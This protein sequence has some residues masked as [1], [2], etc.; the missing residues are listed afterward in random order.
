ML[1][2][3]LFAELSVPAFSLSGFLSHRCSLKC[4]S[5]GSTRQSLRS[6]GQAAA[7]SRSGGHTAPQCPGTWESVL[8][9]NLTVW[10]TGAARV[11][12]EECLWGPKRRHE[13]HSEAWELDP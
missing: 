12:G 1:C 5:Q 4:G 2:N 7:P 10:I 13:S 8:P 9:D 11:A 6:P 3:V